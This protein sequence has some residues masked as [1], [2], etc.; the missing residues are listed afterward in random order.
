M[1]RPSPEICRFVPAHCLALKTASSLWATKLIFSLAT[2]HLKHIFFRRQH[3][4]FLNNFENSDW[5]K[6]ETRLYQTLKKKRKKITNNF[7]GFSC[8][9]YKKILC[10][11]QSIWIVTQSCWETAKRIFIW[12]HKFFLYLPWILEKHTE[13]QVTQIYP[14]L[15]SFAWYWVSQT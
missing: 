2:Y 1:F 14:I 11:D 15:L 4:Y 6:I 9:S 7:W 5:S 13:S 10:R 3:A 8:I 12:I